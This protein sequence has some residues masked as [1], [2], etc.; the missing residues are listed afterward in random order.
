M[1]C[2]QVFEKEKREGELIEYWGRGSSSAITS[3][4]RTT[5]AMCAAGQ[6]KDGGWDKGSV[7]WSLRSGFE[8]GLTAMMKVAENSRRQDGDKPQRHDATELRPA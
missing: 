1:Q 6:R 7:E 5:A 3:R 2:T 8:E 4:V